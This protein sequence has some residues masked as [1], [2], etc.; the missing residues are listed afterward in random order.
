MSTRAKLSEIVLAYPIDIVESDSEH[1]ASS[2]H[3]VLEGLLGLGV[4]VCWQFVSPPE[5]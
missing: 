1:S 3:H 4:K 5:T 2:K